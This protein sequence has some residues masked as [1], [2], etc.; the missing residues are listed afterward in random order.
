MFFSEL[1]LSD[2]LSLIAMNVFEELLVEFFG[3]RKSNCM[4]RIHVHIYIYHRILIG[5]YDASLLSFVGEFVQDTYGFLLVV[6]H[7]VSY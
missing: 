7:K 4:P 3:I 2:F 6:S 5:L 1:F